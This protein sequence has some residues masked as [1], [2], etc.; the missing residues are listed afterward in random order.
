MNASTRQQNRKTSSAELE[1]LRKRMMDQYTFFHPDSVYLLWAQ[2]LEAARTSDD[3]GVRAL[4]AESR[5]YYAAWDRE[6]RK[7]PHP[8]GWLESMDRKHYFAEPQV[9]IWDKARR[10]YPNSLLI[11]VPLNKSFTDLEKDVRALLRFRFLCS[12]T[13]WRRAATARYAPT[14]FG[15]KLDV[16]QNA[17]HVYHAVLEN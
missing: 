3:S 8:D 7:Y 14:S 16:L 17:L 1:R 10:K 5:S 6:V 11:E 2:Y 12:K 9:R 4:L 15:I 13:P